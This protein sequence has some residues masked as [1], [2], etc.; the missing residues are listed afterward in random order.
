[1]AVDAVVGGVEHAVLEPFDRDVAGPERG[2]LDL[3][4]RSVPMDALGLLRPESVRVLERARVHLLVFRGVDI[5]A[6]L[7][8]RRYAVNLLR[9][10]FGPPPSRAL[11]PGQGGALGSFP[12]LV[13]RS[14]LARRIMRRLPRQRQAA[15]Y[16]TL[17]PE[18]PRPNA[19]R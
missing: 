1:M 4:R 11:A 15:A 14:L 12:Y 5:G 19:A 10:R 17:V 8:L 16:P 13:R 6:L 2:V 7:P 9:H 3:A 18:C